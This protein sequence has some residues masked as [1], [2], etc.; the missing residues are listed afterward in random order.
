MAVEYQSG[1]GNEFGRPQLLGLF[2]TFETRYQDRYRGYHKPIML[3]GG[4]GNIRAEHIEKGAFPAGS[5]LVVLGGPAMLIGLGGVGSRIVDRM[6]A[7]A[8]RLPNWESQLRPLVS[9]MSVDTNELDQ[10]KLTHVPPGNRFNIAAFDKAK[11]IEHYRRHYDNLSPEGSRVYEDVAQDLGRLRRHG[12]RLYVATVKPTSIAEKVLGDVGLEAGEVGRAG[13]KVQI[14]EVTPPPE[15]PPQGYYHLNYGRAPA[16]TFGRTINNPLLFELMPENTV[17]INPIT[18][19]GSGFAGVS[20]AAGSSAG[21]SS[22]SATVS[23]GSSVDSSVAEGSSL[24]SSVDAMDAS[25]SVFSTVSSEFFTSSA[26]FD[27]AS[28]AS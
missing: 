2:K 22:A 20:S 13:A 16:H 19:A 25:V 12:L 6:A 10:H 28:I 3:A 26:C 18:A 15:R 14:V 21:A 9:F 5:P 24:T 1:F 27:L 8:K 17:W 7:R 23:F 4:L 11:A